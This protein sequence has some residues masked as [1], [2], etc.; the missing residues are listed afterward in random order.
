MG[1]GGG[2]GGTTTGGGGGVLVASLSLLLLPSPGF[3]E[4]EGGGLTTWLPR[5]PSF[6]SPNR[7]VSHAKSQACHNGW[8]AVPGG[9]GG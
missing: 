9:N 3:E 8:S 2:G 4:A 5:I 1:G 7:H 6:S